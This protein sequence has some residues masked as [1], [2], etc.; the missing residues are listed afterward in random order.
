LSE[1]VNGIGGGVLPLE[2]SVYG[3]PP[4]ITFTG[5]ALSERA[6]DGKGKMRGESRKPLVLEVYLTCGR[7]DAGQT[8]HH[9]LP[10]TVKS[11]VSTSGRD[12]L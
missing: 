8:N 12:R 3:P 4:R 6:R 1:V 11:V 5:H 2:P 10:K 7:D 9:V